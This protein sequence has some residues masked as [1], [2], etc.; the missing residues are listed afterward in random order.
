MFSHLKSVSNL[1]RA[2]F[3]GGCFTSACARSPTG[4]VSLALPSER[5][6]VQ[7][8]LHHQLSSR[9]KAAYPYH[10]PLQHSTGTATP[11]RTTHSTTGNTR[12][13]VRL[14]ESLYEAA[15]IAWS[16]A[17]NWWEGF[18][19]GLHV[20]RAYLPRGALLAS[21]FQ[22]SHL[23][24]ELQSPAMSTGDWTA[25]NPVIS[26]MSASS[27]AD[28]RASLHLT[29]LCTFSSFSTVKRK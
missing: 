25:A 29:T 12:T 21:D 22:A 3:A 23:K 9:H 13:K 10:W 1:P 11:A 24:R 6:S 27:V 26:C 28:R 18:E 19:L 8:A 2:S 7:R 15:R 14:E 20:G 16:Q 17:C 4:F 5:A